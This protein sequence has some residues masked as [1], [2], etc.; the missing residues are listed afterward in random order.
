MALWSAAAVASA[1]AIVGGAG[2]AP[3]ASTTIY[4]DK[5]MSSCSDTGPA[6]S[7]TPLCTIAQAMKRLTA[8]ATV[9]IGNGTYAETATPPV[10]GTAS[11]PITITAW[12]GR[13]PVVG[14]GASY[15]VVLS[16]WSYL[17]ISG[18]TISGTIH[19]GIYVIGG[20]HNTVSNNEV[21]LA[22]NPVSGQTASGIRLT[23]TADATVTDNNTHD[24]SDSGI[25]LTG[26]TTRALVA[27][28]VS[29]A[30]ARQYQRN[31]NGINVI[32]AGNTILGNITHD[33]EDS[34]IQFYPGGNNNVAVGN[35]T[36]NNGDHGIDDYNVTGGRITGNT[37]FRN[38]TS[39]INIEGTSGNYVVEN[40]IAVDNAVY[41]A[42]QGISC[43]RRAGNIG[44]WDSAPATTTVDHNLVWLSKSGTQYVFGSKYTSLSAMQAAT[45][46]EQHG[47]QANPQF[48]DPASW[49]LQLQE[50]SA[51]IDRGDSGAAGEQ[52]KDLLGNARV[53]DPNVPNTY[54][55][56]PRLYDDLGAYEFQPSVTPPPPP[57]PPPAAPTAVLTV[58]PSS[59]TAPVT[60][61][62]DASGSSDPQG[63][64]LTYG[65]DF[66][67]GTS[68]GPQ[69][70]P[71]AS[72]TYSAAGTFTVS[73][74]VTNT[75]GLTSTA[76]QSVSVAAPPTSKPTYVGGIANNYSTSTHT[77]GY[78]TVYKST[79]VKVGDL[80]VLTLQLTGTAASGTVSGTDAAG[81]AYQAVS[82]V[83]DPSGDRLVV[84][85]GVAQQPLAVGDKITVTFPSAAT[86]RLSGDEYAGVSRVDQTAAA[87][88]TGTSFSS[89]TAQ[90]SSG[91]E[92]AFGAVATFAGTSNPT[93]SSGWSG[94]G[95]YSVSGR[96][97]AKAHQLPAS[98]AYSAT[99]SATGAWLAT[100]VTLAP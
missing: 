9:A 38:C 77:S 10:G 84:L 6:T 56:G 64:T 11:A 22:G 70:S 41:P 63:Q 43:S 65:F 14:T 28:N 18:L 49:N 89:G 58:T 78:I 92:V 66:G 35:V 61:K 48:V 51:A 16:G 53:D 94:I 71:T 95:T 13:M 46:Q 44:V 21:T 100:V 8:G 91:G 82:S 62:A 42:Y 99:G 73:V 37:V 36:Y 1:V 32:A 40:N 25:Y 23:N 7:T 59:G 98:G 97:L 86:Y 47:V 67:D 12:S 54:A 2:A 76:T 30:N 39:G 26:S 79:G 3:A 55:E 87:S 96:Y 80:V 88:G 83:T 81:N 24:N 50:G 15:G 31:A 74:S 93:W 69:T 52:A 29:S 90:A 72:H 45:G 17:T 75:S 85:A 68:T 57:P 4:V 5:T 19:E 33:N 20:S 34:G 27:R 60:V